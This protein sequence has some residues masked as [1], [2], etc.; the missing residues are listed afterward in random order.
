MNSQRLKYFLI[1]C[2][3]ES[4]RK[5]A[6][7]LNITPAA[8]SKA[9]K[10]LEFEIGTILLVPAGRG[11]FIT[12]DGRELARRAQP[13]IEDLE[14]LKIALKEK[15]K[16]KAIKAKPIRIGSFEI[17]TTHCLGNLISAFNDAS[18]LI[19][20][21]LIPGDIEKSLLDY[22]VDYGITYIPIPTAG[23]IYK[24]VSFFEMK[25]YGLAGIFDKIPF[26]QLPFVIPLQTFLNSPG[27]SKGL[28][29]WPET[30]VDRLT[31]YKVEMM[32]SALELC[33]QGKAVAYLPSFVIKQHNKTVKDAYSLH[34]IAFPAAMKHEKYTIY[35][36]KRKTDPDDQSFI[37]IAA[38]LRNISS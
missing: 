2:E 7:V 13:L 15:R 33:R 8:L 12:E 23:I 29:G 5:A 35:I 1:V 31:K 30:Q 26:S 19:L 38:S 37:K 25:I 4:I 22:K 17:F 32:E 10:Q 36:A 27:N 18:E 16:P 28:D 24:S 21:E 9:I 14:K 34:P 20:H 6:E 3:T 11:I